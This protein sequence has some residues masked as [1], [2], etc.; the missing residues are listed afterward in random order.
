MQVQKSSKEI[1]EE[2][3]KNRREPTWLKEKRL[4]ALKTFE[5]LQQPNYIYGLNIK[6]NT[7]FRLENVKIDN[8]DEDKNETD[9]IIIQDLQEAV[10]KHDFLKNYLMN[11][12]NPKE[13][14]FTAFHAS[15]FSTGLFIH[16]KK[17]VDNPIILSLDTKGKDKIEHIIVIME[18]GTSATIIED[19]NTKEKESYFRSAV[20]EIFV[21]E[22]AKLNYVSVQKLSNK[23]NNF[24]LK[25]ALVERNSE[26]NWLS[27]CIGSSLTLSDIDTILNGEGS[28][29]TNW[30][31]F[32]GNEEQQFKIASSTIHAAPYTE[33][34]M[35]NKGILN[36][37]SRAIYQGLI[38]INSNAPNSNGYQKIDTLILS[39]E[40]EIDPIPNLEIDNHNVKCS[41]GA[42]ISQVD[43]EKIF[44][45]MSRGLSEEEAKKMIIKG[46][47]EP[48]IDKIKI[49]AMKE[50]V[51]NIITKKL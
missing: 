25:R 1:V 15:F 7:D 13:N 45:L 32:L 24:E 39:D 6:L 8:L 48:M 29:T 27:C 50:E 10:H 31:I 14:K 41:H 34:D 42:T 33:S 11:I 44:Y 26:I 47:F 21:K 43:K 9:N 3:S 12:V 49:E 30:G 5:A 36:D 20:T 46:F 51:R 4:N 18:S 22:N 38:K 23:T 37:R 35:L 40:A 16:I 28:K 2:L 19:I 17:S